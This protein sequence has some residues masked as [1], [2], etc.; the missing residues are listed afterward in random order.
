MPITDS[1][2]LSSP[3]VRRVAQA[4]VE[5][6]RGQSK[7]ASFVPTHPVSAFLGAEAGQVGAKLAFA[8]MRQRRIQSA[9]RALE[10]AR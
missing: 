4:Y 6:T 7:T 5:S 8:Q 1:D 2:L 3:T 10:A 9:L